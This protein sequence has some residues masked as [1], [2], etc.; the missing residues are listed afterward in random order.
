MN[1]LAVV[2]VLRMKVNECMFKVT[3]FV[4]YLPL[5]KIYKNEIFMLQLCSPSTNIFVLLF[6]HSV[7]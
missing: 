2:I 1:A 5:Q 4:L 6:P 7:T 3:H